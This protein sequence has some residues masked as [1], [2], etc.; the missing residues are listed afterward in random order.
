MNAT[1]A[2]KRVKAPITASIIVP[3]YN[4]EKNIATCLH[5]IASQDFSEC[6]EVIASDGY[7]TDAT[8][9]K[10]RALGAHV[11]FERKRTIAAGRQKG[12]LAAR[13]EFLV[14]TDADSAAEKNWLSE[15]L[16]PFR[17]ERVVC[18]FGPVRLR[19][20]NWWQNALC[21]VYNA[22]LRVSLAL[23]L[24]SGAGMNLGARAQAFKKIGGFRVDLATGEDIELQKRLQRVGR[25]V[26]AP[27][28]VVF[29]STRRLRK[30]GFPRFFLFHAR[31]W[32]RLHFSGAPSRKYERIR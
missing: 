11:V 2:A 17:D 7:S 5:A 22:W 18:V 19:E 27:R 26:F 20:G 23:G 13:G 3:T 4:E 9:R 25:I 14:F 15:L 31:N 28:A 1:K 10:A 8:V 29:T 32:L 12:A 21:A 6:F 30:W 24:P 16:K